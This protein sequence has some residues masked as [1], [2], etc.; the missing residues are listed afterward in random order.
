MVWRGDYDGRCTEASTEMDTL[1][2]RMTDNVTLRSLCIPSEE[3]AFSF[4]KIRLYYIANP[5][6]CVAYT[7]RW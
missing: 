3:S 6:D 2:K 7:L 5:R 4:L 1:L